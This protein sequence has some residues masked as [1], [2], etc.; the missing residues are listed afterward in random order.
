EAITFAFQAYYRTTLLAEDTDPNKMHDLKTAL[1]DAQVYAPEQ[2]Q[3][4]VELFLGGADRDKLDPILDTCVATYKTLG[5]DGQ[6]D[7]KGKAKTCVR[8]YAFLSSILPY[9]NAAWEKLSIFLNL[10]IPK[11]PA[12]TEEDLSKGILESIHIDMY[13]GAK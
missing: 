7:F 10:L 2:V 5:E 4:I 3:K 12:P 6:I 9:N 1:D 8:V 11:L 13:R